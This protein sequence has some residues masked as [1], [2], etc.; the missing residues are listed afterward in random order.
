MPT[1]EPVALWASTSLGVVALQVSVPAVPTGSVAVLVPALGYESSTSHRTLR[2]LA[3]GL[4]EAGHLAVRV[5][6]PGTGDAGGETGRATPEQLAAA[7]AEV[8]AALRAAGAERLSLVGLRAGAAIAELAAGREPV[9][10]LVLWAA[11]AGRRYRRELSLIGTPV[12]DGVGLPEGSVVVGG[13]TFPA[14]MLEGLAALDLAALAPAGVAHALVLDRD[15]VHPQDA[16]AD[17]LRATGADVEHRA[18]PG[19]DRFLDRPS[20]DAEVGVEAVDAILAWF[21]RAEPAVPADPGVEPPGE[22][23]ARIPWAGGE[24]VE[25]AVA[26]GE[27]RLAAVLTHG[28]AR[29]RDVLLLLDSGSDPRHGPGRA[30]VEFARE[31]ALRGQDVVRVDFRGWGESPHLDAASGR[32]YDEHHGED[33]REAAAALRRAGYE[34]VVLSGLCA[35]A[36]VSLDVARREPTDAVLALNA[37]LYWQRGDPIEALMSTT[38]ER[39]RDEIA[40]IR[41]RCAAGEWDRA[42]EAGQRPPAGV[43]LDELAERRVPV[44]LVFAEGDDGVEYLRDRLGRRTA[45]LE[46]RGS[47]RVREVPGVDHSMTRVWLRPQVLDV[48]AEELAGL[49]ARD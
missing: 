46:A 6:L 33:A 19:H 4:A 45:L 11:A 5:D 25:E 37:Q 18:T 48:L 41:R 9:D 49:L 16:L 1:R 31:L 14:P 44:S 42:D 35:G 26:L 32:P 30:W 10:A 13:W 8:L 20:E 47:L 15:D 3:E 2:A 17:A 34:R 7:L 36:W 28:P 38:R 40:D 29:S 23:V 24:V 22:P 27:H 12:P 21:A 43:W 39:R